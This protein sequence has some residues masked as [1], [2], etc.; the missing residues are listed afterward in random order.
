[1]TTAADDSAVEEA[2]EALLA[3]RRVPEEA[4]GL[5][6]FAGA[7][8]AAADRTPRPNAALAELL[9][10]GLITD[11]SSP[12]ARTAPSAGSPPSRRAHGRR[13]RRF[14]MILSALIAKFVSAGAVAQAA[15]GATVV[16]VTLTGAG[17]A[18]VLPDPVQDT[19]AGVVETVSPLDLPDSGDAEES[20]P[21]AVPVVDDGAEEEDP[22]AETGEAEAQELTL[23]QW[24]EGPAPQQSFG[25]WVSQGAR[26]G[27]VDGPTVQRWAHERNQQRRNP[28]EAEQTPAPESETE[29]EDGESEDTQVESTDD[30]DRRDDGRGNGRGSGR[31]NGGGNGGGGHDR[32]RP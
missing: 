17:A 9:A 12:S 2:F 21:D 31:G 24:Q 10:T 26:M 8:R 23:E 13:R 20:D 30:R 29:V 4:A 1:M 19:V 6:A 7:V 22:A 14:T 28:E 16:V 18:G 3:G 27:Y 32:G 11:L 5:A 25:D 15:T